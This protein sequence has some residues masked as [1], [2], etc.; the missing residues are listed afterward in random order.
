M[1]NGKLPLYYALSSILEEKILSGDY[2]LNTK[3]PS[4]REL[5]EMYEVSRITVR[6]AVEE[7]VRNGL[8]EKK[9]GKGAFVSSNTINQGLV[10]IYS[11]T[12]EMQK[13]GLAS[14]TKVL[15]R[16]IEMPSPKIQKVLELSP[17]SQVIY[18]ERVRLNKDEV[19]FIIEG[20]YFPYEE[21]KFL[22]EDK[23]ESSSLYGIL[24]NHG[25]YFDSAVEKYKICELNSYEKKIFGLEDTSRPYFGML[26]RRTV[27]ING[28][29]EGYST[30]VTNGDIYEFTVHLK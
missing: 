6:A 20:S 5:S 2:P 25:K 4:E 29:P 18:L 21:Y 22:L 19:P 15:R 26:I 11:F 8:V 17:D 13:K 3:L 16:I 24:E 23:A 27:S 28:K 1:K 10:G 30:V 12:D 7:L 14:N 9:H